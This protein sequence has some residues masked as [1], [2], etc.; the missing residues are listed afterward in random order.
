M[1]KEAL[2]ILI[3]TEIQ[4]LNRV[5][6]FYIACFN[7]NVLNNV[8]CCYDDDAKMGTE[9]HSNECWALMIGLHHPFVVLH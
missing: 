6:I 9:S 5:Y 1:N 2:P 8:S 7:R 3:S 4:R